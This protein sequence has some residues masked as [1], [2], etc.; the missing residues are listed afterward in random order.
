MPFRPRMAFSSNSVMRPDG[1]S[2]MNL[3]YQWCMSSARMSSR[4]EP[5]FPIGAV[6]QVHRGRERKNEGS[7]SDWRRGRRLEERVVGKERS[8]VTEPQVLIRGQRRRKVTKT[9]KSKIST[10]S[11][12]SAARPPGFSSR[13]RTTSR[14]QW[15]CREQNSGVSNP[16]RS[17]RKNQGAPKINP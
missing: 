12:A 16:L 14:L 3:L 9:V 17:W 7:S 6:R 4:F 11:A 15:L 13:S 5:W 8:P 2:L 10:A 1:D